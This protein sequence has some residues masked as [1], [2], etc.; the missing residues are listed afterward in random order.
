[1]N[2]DIEMLNKEKDLLNRK[3]DSLERYVEC[4]LKEK[5]ADPEY[6][7]NLDIFMKEHYKG[8]YDDE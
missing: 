4:L 1:M 8:P 5:E 6:K 2:K 3:I 7:R